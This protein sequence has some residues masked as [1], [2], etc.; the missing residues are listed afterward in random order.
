MNTYSV[1]TQAYCGMTIPHGD[2]F[3]Y[4]EAKERAKRRMEWFEKRI[5]GAI[6][7]LSPNTWELEE[8]EDA[9]MVPD[10]CGILEIRKGEAR[11]Q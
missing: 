7:R 3:T 8:P 9:M 6:S 1:A 10:A 5:G 4:Q 11:I 2:G